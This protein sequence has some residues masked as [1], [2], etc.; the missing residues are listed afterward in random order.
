MTDTDDDQY[1]PL[2]LSTSF[3]AIFYQRLV[4]PVAKDQG[5]CIDILEF[6]ESE[7]RAVQSDLLAY[8]CVNSIQKV[9]QLE[10][11]LTWLALD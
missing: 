7:S 9:Y 6:R 10:V 4:R 5:C 8:C 1:S 3:S 11:A 2:G